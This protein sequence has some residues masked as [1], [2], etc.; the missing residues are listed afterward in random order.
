LAGLADKN[1]SVEFRRIVVTEKNKG[2]GSEALRLIKQL[3]FEH[4]ASMA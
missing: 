3:V 4:G 2:Y 1:Q